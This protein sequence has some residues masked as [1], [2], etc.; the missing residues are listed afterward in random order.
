MKR[1]LLT[2]L[3][4]V[5]LCSCAKDDKPLTSGQNSG[6]DDSVSISENLSKDGE[7]ALGLV[8]QWNEAMGITVATDPDVPDFLTPDQQNLF[9]AARRMIY[10]LRGPTPGYKTDYSVTAHQGVGEASYLYALDTAFASYADFD[11]ALH[12]VCTDD[13]CN[14][15]LPNDPCNPVMEHDGKLYALDAA[16]GADSTY[17]STAYNLVSESDTEIVFEFIGTY[18]DEINWDK[19]GIEG[20]D[21]TKDNTVT[22][23]AKLILTDKG[24]RFDSFYIMN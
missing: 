7:I 4:L 1:I 21:K 12:A 2:C 18:N 16:R 11:T 24:W 20:R 10:G 14:I 15:L 13:F 17:I 6:V 22:E 9:R 23:T 8:P 19:G 3:T 5:L